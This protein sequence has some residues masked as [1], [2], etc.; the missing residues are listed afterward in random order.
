MAML[1]GLPSSYNKD[2]QEDKEP[3]FDAADTLALTLPIM[4]G[5][6][7]TLTVNAARM[8][9]ALDDSMLATD[10][11]DYLVRQG[12]PFRESHRLVGELVRVARGRPLRKLSLEEFRRVS[13][14]FGADVHAVFDV[15]AAVERRSSSGGTAPSAVR[16]Q[17]ERAKKMLIR[18]MTTPSTL[19]VARTNP[20][21]SHGIEQTRP[22]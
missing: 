4:A 13:E 2:L 11:A 10:L 16:T 5:V 17:I 8:A 6:V 15:R 18:T 14:L 19:G 22:L 1:K 21:A 3:L 9:A 20:D 7:R 12:V